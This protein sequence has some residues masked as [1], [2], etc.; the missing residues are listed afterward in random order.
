MVLFA[1]CTVLQESTHVQAQK[2][3][4]A[5]QLPLVRRGPRFASAF[6]TLTWACDHQSDRINLFDLTD[7]LFLLAPFNAAT[8]T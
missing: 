2:F 5:S 1:L 3:R 6:W 7:N 4:N 8:V